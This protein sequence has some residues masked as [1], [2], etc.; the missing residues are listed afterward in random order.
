MLSL[1]AYAKRRGVSVEAVSQA[2]K[3][4]RLSK[5]VVRGAHRR[6]KGISDPD[7][8]DREW[9]ETTRVEMIPLSGPAAQRG[10]GG[11]PS[12]LAV[13]RSRLEMARAELAEMEIAQR[14]G[15]LV[16]AVDLEARLVGIFGGCKTKLLAVPSRARQEDP[17]LTAAQLALFEALIRE[18]LEDLASPAKRPSPRRVAR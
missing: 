2:A 7:L 16:K 1:R 13:G 10:A 15:E 14:K 8:A 5:S 18:A 4:G 17:D 12:P 9:A 3:N 6:V 11:E